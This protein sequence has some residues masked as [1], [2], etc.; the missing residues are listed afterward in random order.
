M[1]FTFYHNNINVSDL[2]KSVEFYKEALGLTVF[3]RA[4]NGEEALELLGQERVDILV[5]DVSMPLLDGIGLLEQVRKTD[6]RMRFVILSGYSEFEYARAAVRLDV[7]DYILKPI[8]EEELI[9]AL[10]GCVEKLK[11]M[12]EEQDSQIDRKMEFQ[13]FLEGGFSPEERRRYLQN[14][15]PGIPPGRYRAAVMKI[16]LST[17]GAYRLTDVTRYISSRKSGEELKVWHLGGSNF[18][19]LLCLCKEEDP[20]A[21]GWR[22]SAAGEQESAVSGEGEAS[23]GWFADLQNEMEIELGVYS[24]LTVSNVFCDLTSLPEVYGTVEK[25]QRY[26][27]IEGYGSCMNEEKLLNRTDTDVVIDKEKFAGLI[28]R[29]DIAGAGEYVEGLF[30]N[31]IQKEVSVDVLY[32]IA[33][34][35]AL[36]LREIRL[37]Y[38][39]RDEGRQLYDVIG[40]IWQAEDISAIRTMLLSEISDIISWMNMENMQYTP[41]VRQIIAEV[42]NNYQNDMNLK[43]LAYKYHMNTSYLGQ[44]FQKE[45]GCPFSQYLNNVRNG[46]AKNLILTTNLRINDIAREVGYS[47]TS[48]FYRKF[49]QSYGVSP[50]ALREMKNY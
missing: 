41:V 39:I 42:K 23:G 47:D 13:C 25:M 30:I 26:L 11:K 46:I 27:L 43:T 2:E 16:D 8:N 29:K 24:F 35:I 5:T 36:I 50:A 44:I 21:S 9:R 18:L 15:V 22:A 14:I 33:A 17:L 3:Y 49:K 32:Q 4:H 20:A 40:E 6:S 37:E 12:D 1:K 10:T 7:E 31:N 19:L 34:R 38:N 48:Y 45:V 28:L